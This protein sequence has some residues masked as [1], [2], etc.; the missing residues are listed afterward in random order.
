MDVAAKEAARVMEGLVVA[1]KVGAQVVGM[2]EE[3]TVGAATAG[4]V[5]APVVVARQ[6][7]HLE[8]LEVGRQ[9][10]PR[11]RLL[12]EELERLLLRRP[13]HR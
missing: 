12:L 2:A 4:A 1:A 8:A 9:V 10:L 7:H 11:N 3:V 6:I 13:V 5:V